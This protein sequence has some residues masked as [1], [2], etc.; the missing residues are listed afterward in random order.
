MEIMYYLA[1]RHNKKNNVSLWWVLGRKLEELGEVLI[2]IVNLINIWF[3][4]KTVT[5]NS[6]KTWEVIETIGGYILGAAIM[7][8]V[9]ILWLWF[10]KQAV[11]R[12]KK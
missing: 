11:V 9:I 6:T 12:R 10:N 7:V 8:G 3:L 5:I 2:I 1:V 4:A